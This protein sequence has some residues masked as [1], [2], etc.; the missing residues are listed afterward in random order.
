MGTHIIYDCIQIISGYQL[1]KKEDDDSE[2]ILD[3][4]VK[5]DIISQGEDDQ[6]VKTEH[7]KNNGNNEQLYA[8]AFCLSAFH[9]LFLW[10]IQAFPL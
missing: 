5:V 4:Y 7:F 2:S 6:G 3:P 10:N 8:S 1:P 9:L